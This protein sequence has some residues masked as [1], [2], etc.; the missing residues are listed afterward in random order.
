MRPRALPEI[1]RLLV[2]AAT[3]AWAHGLSSARRLMGKPDEQN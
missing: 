3:I 2:L 1:R